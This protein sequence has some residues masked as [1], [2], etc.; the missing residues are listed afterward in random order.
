MIRF[1]QDRITKSIISLNLEEILANKSS[2][3]NIQL[4]PGDEIRVYPETIF[5]TVKPVSIKGV[6]RLPG[7]YNLKTDMTLKDLI[8]EAGGLNENIYR[9]KVEWLG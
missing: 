9:Y 8:L 2:D 1:N 3:Q 6:V 5:N 4:I 7:K